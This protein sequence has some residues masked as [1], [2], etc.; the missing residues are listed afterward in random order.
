VVQGL[1]GS[2]GWDAGATS[3]LL[4]TGAI[5]LCG[6][7]GV[8]A[9]GWSS[10]RTGDRKGHCM[11]GQLIAGLFLVLSVIP[12]QP[13]ELVFAWLCVGGF[14]AMFW[15]SPFWVL[16]TLTLTSSAAAVSIGIINTCGNIAGAMGSPA[17]GA[18][19]DAGWGDGAALIFVAVCFAA[20]A[21]FVSMVRVPRR[22]RTND[23]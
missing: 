18:M 11:A 7:A 17:V 13:W 21:V 1:L 9:S 4:W 2:A 6:V 16:P 5:Y 14:F 3:V 20:G 22:E 23:R 8:V 12:G 10:D 19:K 15:F